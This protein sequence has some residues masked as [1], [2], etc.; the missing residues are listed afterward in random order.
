MKV[1]NKK[2]RKYYTHEDI[3]GMLKNP[4]RRSGPFSYLHPQISPTGQSFSED[5][6]S[7]AIVADAKKRYIKN[8]WMQNRRV[9]EAAST[10]RD[11]TALMSLE[12]T[13]TAAVHN[14]IQGYDMF[15][16]NGG[17]ES[18][19]GLRHID[20]DEKAQEVEQ[21]A[22]HEERAAALDTGLAAAG[23]TGMA[24]QNLTSHE[25]EIHLAAHQTGVAKEA[26]ESV[27]PPGV[28]GIV[29]NLATVEPPSPEFPEDSPPPGPPVPKSPVSKKKST[30]N[31]K[32]KQHQQALTEKGITWR[33]S[34]STKKLKEVLDG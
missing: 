16:S 11:V 33:K 32:K 31:T 19:S 27:L 14:A 3:A 1:Q 30:R 34:W 22:D 23:L 4:T 9:S 15:D 17:R 8:G 25:S 28:S 26:A 13:L 24:Q 18:L 20:E 21:Q 2:A 5:D 10:K 7:I 29:G 6:D 12:G